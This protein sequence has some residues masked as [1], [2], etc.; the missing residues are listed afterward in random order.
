MSYDFILANPPYVP[1]RN[2]P[3][4]KPWAIKYWP[5]KAL[6]G[7]QDGLFFVRQ[8]LKHAKSRLKKGGSIWMEF[9]SSQ[10]KK[11]A[12]LIKQNKYSSYKFHRDQYKRWRYVVI[13]L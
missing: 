3:K 2:K 11:I 8:F 1:E 13:S 7:G 6:F 10:K 12:K 9:D 4:M 5:Q